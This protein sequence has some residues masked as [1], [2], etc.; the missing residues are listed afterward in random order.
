MSQWRSHFACLPLL[1][2]RERRAHQLLGR[3]KSKQKKNY[4]NDDKYLLDG[5]RKEEIYRGILFC[6]YRYTFFSFL[7]FLIF[8]VVVGPNTFMWATATIISATATNC[9]EKPRWSKT[10]W[11]LWDKKFVLCVLP[12]HRQ[13]FC[14]WHRERRVCG[15]PMPVTKV[16]HTSSTPSTPL[17][18]SMQ[19]G[20]DDF[21]SFRSWMFRRRC[22]WWKS[23]FPS[24]FLHH[25]PFLVLHSCKKKKKTGEKG[26]QI[27][28]EW[29]LGEFSLR[30]LFTGESFTVL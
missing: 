2:L 26:R 30:N 21:L 9:D 19:P 14:G 12:H 15:G 25:F 17:S 13:L 5:Q 6:V 24:F 10:M 28:R 23:L 11:N 27:N 7:F 20:L 4:I 18:S 1:P 22:W 3:R 8:V 16:A 29:A